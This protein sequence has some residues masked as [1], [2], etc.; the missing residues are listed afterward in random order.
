MRFEPLQNDV[1]RYFEEDIGYEEDGQSYIILRRAGGNMQVFS[2]AEDDGI[3]NV[4]PA[5]QSLSVVLLPCYR[6]I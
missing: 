3:R 2:E 6:K 5:K 4:G 1:G